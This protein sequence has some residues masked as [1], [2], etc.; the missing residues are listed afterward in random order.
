MHCCFLHFTETNKL[1]ILLKLRPSK[2]VK[3]PV[4]DL[5]WCS[6]WT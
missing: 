2:E 1:R 4:P 5:L 6:S 3:L